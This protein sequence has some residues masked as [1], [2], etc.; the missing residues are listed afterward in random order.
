[1]KYLF[2][3]AVVGGA[4]WFLA[5]RPPQVIEKIVEVAPPPTLAP[6][7]RATPLPSTPRQM[8]TSVPAGPTLATILQ[9]VFDR[10]F[11][12]GDYATPM[13]EAREA[14]Q[15]LPAK[16][17]A[18]SDAKDP[19][20]L[21]AAMQLCQLMDRVIRDTDAALQQKESSA[22]K[23]SAAPAFGVSA[24]ARQA[25]SD[26]RD[27]RNREAFFGEIVEKRW[28]ADID[29]L[30]DTALQ[31][32]RS[33]GL[34]DPTAMREL[35]KAGHAQRIQIEVVQVIGGGVLADLY[36]SYAIADYSRSIGMGGSAAVGYQPSG[37]TV[38]IQGFPD[39][40]DGQKASI[41]AYR[42]GATRYGQS[43]L[44]KW[45]FVSN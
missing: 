1:M 36:Q 7:A 33:L 2:F 22:P 35:E 17:G 37:K 19:R 18:A 40:T 28:K 13:L 12:S 8:R 31:L 15:Q 11:S 16:L 30:R 27:A 4:V 10:V 14:V 25:A 45:V 9:P 38:F 43:T 20:K 32:M 5:N 6:I 42:D 29:Q 23:T 26:A 3:L 24:S 21:N 44:E 41:N 34:P 39:A